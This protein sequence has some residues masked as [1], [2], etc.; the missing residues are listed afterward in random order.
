M[1]YSTLKNSEFDF[2]KSDRKTPKLPEKKQPRRENFTFDKNNSTRK[3]SEFDFL[4]RDRK[5]PKPIEN[6]SRKE[7]FTFDKKNLQKTGVSEKLIG[8]YKLEKNFSSRLGKG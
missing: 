6:T 4:K 1:S 8:Y 7:N 5:T 2:L 3:N